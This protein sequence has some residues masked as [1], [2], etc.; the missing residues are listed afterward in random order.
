MA[1]GPFEAHDLTDVHTHQAAKLDLRVFGR[2]HMVGDR[3]ATR[4]LVAEVDREY[5]ANVLAWIVEHQTAPYFAALRH[6]AQLIPPGSA[7]QGPAQARS[8]RRKR[9]MVLSDPAGTVTFMEHFDGRDRNRIDDVVAAL[10]AAWIAA[11]HLR[12]GQVVNEAAAIGG[13]HLLGSEDDAWQQAFDTQAQKHHELLEQQAREATGMS[14][15]DRNMVA[16]L[17]FGVHSMP[18][19]RLQPSVTLIRWQVLETKTGA[20]HL[21]GRSVQDREGRVSTRVA[22][23]DPVTRIAV[24]QSGRLYTLDGL[25]ARDDDASHVFGMW[26]PANGID[27]QACVDVT[28]EYAPAAINPESVVQVPC[29]TL[30]QSS[31]HVSVPTETHVRPGDWLLLHCEEQL[32]PVGAVVVA[33]TENDH[34]WVVSPRQR[35]NVGF[36]GDVFWGWWNERVVDTGVRDRLRRG[37]PGALEDMFLLSGI[38]A[39]VERAT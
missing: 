22:R 38:I 23:W 9:P 18:P 26:A 34:V 19:P 36:T 5:L 33:P 39:K 4:H 30:H 37:D 8:A 29:D 27:V 17:L 16:S 10:R 12:L 20:R 6:R 35:H 7:A 1:A 32:Q 15:E 21:L 25:P 28:A 11:P 2:V 13:L 3:E 31:V 24:T 14:P